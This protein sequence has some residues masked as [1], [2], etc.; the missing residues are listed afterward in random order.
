M[1]IYDTRYDKRHRIHVILYAYLSKDKCYGLIADHV[2]DMIQLVSVN[3][4][5]CY[6]SIESII[7]ETFNC[8]CHE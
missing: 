3:I 1:Q 6:L 7:N 8:Y 5:L 4:L 2:L